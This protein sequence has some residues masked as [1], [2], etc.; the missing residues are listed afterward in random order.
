MMQPLIIQTR[1]RFFHGIPALFSMQDV[2]LI[3]NY[4]VFC[5]GFVQHV[6]LVVNTV[7]YLS[8]ISKTIHFLW[9][10]FPLLATK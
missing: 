10:S 4:L 2:H 8:S 5:L 7:C 3:S 6:I 9:G 1:G